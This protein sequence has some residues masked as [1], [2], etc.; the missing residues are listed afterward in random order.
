M[1]LEFNK[2]R[3]NLKLSLFDSDD[4]DKDFIEL[5]REKWIEV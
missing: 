4:Y 2:E 1:F 3:L 5:F